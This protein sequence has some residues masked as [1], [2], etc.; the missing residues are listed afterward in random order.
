[1]RPDHDQDH[2]HRDYYHCNQNVNYNF[3]LADFT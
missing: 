1:M 2:H 3:T